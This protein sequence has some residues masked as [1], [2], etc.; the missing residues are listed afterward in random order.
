[1]LLRPIEATDHDDVLALNEANVELLAPLDRAGLVELSGIAELA[2][3]IEHDGAFAGF[4][5]GL[6]PATTYDSVNYRWFTERYDDFWYLDRI[7]LVDRVRRLG[8]GSQ[9]YDEIEARAV[10]H[11]RVALEVNLDP[12]NE[13]SLL[14]HRGRGYVDV[15]EQLVG[16]HLVGLMVKEVDQ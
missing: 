2:A 15:H 12:P 13:P 1:M 8:L 7:V 6:L 9:V 4:V 14:F 11:G 10:G 3:V 16:D 5:L